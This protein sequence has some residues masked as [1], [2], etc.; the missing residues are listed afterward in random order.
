MERGAGSG[1]QGAGSIEIEC[2]CE[3]T[4]PETQSHRVSSKQQ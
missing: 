2:E 4:H 1:E 3:I